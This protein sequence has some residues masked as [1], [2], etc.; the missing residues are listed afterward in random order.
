MNLAPDLRKKILKL[1][2]RDVYTY[3][4]G[5]PRFRRLCDQVGI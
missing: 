3:V 1:N 4:D 2:E 5:L